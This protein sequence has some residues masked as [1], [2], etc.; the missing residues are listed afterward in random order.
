MGPDS[1]LCPSNLPV[2]F[3]LVPDSPALQAGAGGLQGC[4]ERVWR[5]R[6]VLS[7]RGGG[8]GAQEQGGPLPQPQAQAVLSLRSWTG[9]HSCGPGPLPPACL[10]LAPASGDPA[11]PPPT[12]TGLGEPAG[13]GPALRVGGGLP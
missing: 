1:L 12:G 2:C 8:F 3:L 4:L 7:P 6:G 11:P 5:E 10:N 13:E 9:Q